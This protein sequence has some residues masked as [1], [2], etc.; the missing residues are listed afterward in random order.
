MARPL[1]IA[2]PN[3]WH[4]VMNRGLARRVVFGDDDDRQGFL[5]LLTQCGRRWEVWASAVVLLPN[6]Y[7]VVLH[8]RRGN[9]SRAMRHLDGVYT[10]RFNRRH[11]RDGPLMRGRFRS[12]LVQ[13]ERYLLEVVR[14]VHSNPVRAGLVARAGDYPWSSHRHYLSQRKSPQWLR[15]S[16]RRCRW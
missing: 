13:E 4:H 11:N 9:L 1:R 5:D 12:R 10:Q 2:V 14:Y 6:H 16:G 15:T 8:D 3:G 7:H